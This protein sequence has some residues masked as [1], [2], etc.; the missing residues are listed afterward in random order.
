MRGMD[1]AE[2]EVSLCPNV[3]CS[4]AVQCQS[5]EH[6]PPALDLHVVPL[7]ALLV[8]GLHRD[9]VRLEVAHILNANGVRRG[10]D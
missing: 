5:T 6:L 7:E 3:K 4:P 10:D 2:D 8:L 1:V 9:D